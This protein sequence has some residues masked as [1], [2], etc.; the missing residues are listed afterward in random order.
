MMHFATKHLSLPTQPAAAVG[1][2]RAVGELYCHPTATASASATASARHG[3]G[4]AYA[5]APPS[6]FQA[7]DDGAGHVQRARELSE[8]EVSR[9]MEN[10]F[11]TSGMDLQ[12]P[13]E[14]PENGRGEDSLSLSALSGGCSSPESVG[15]FSGPPSPSPSSASLSGVRGL[16]V[17]PAEARGHLSAH[18]LKQLQLA[19]AQAEEERVEREMAEERADE[20]ARSEAQAAAQAELNAHL[21]KAARAGRL[22]RVTACIERGADVNYEAQSCSVLHYAAFY[23]HKHIVRLLVERGADVNKRNLSGVTPL[24]WALEKGELELMQMLVERGADVNV[25]DCDELTPLHKAVSTKQHA[26][27]E[28]LLR[29]CTATID[30]DAAAS[31]ANQRLTA[32]HMAATVG[33][34]TA[35]RLLLSA[36]ASAATATTRGATPL[37]KAAVRGHSEAV[38]VLVLEGGAAVDA[39]DELG[40]TP[41]HSAAFYHR[42]GA[43]RALRALGA[44]PH[45]EDR[46]GSS[47]LA[48]AARKNFAD[49]TAALSEP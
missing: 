17:P 18:D 25:G 12:L 40:R 24:H 47:A 21:L 41:L 42:V 37:H 7:V 10:F 30:V 27:L 11:A 35:V 3:D 32:L 34:V 46:F 5:H 19:R 9:C 43:V 28:Y 8:S 4:E 13:E 15:S 22:K 20:K 6:K 1:S 23:N 26:A 45:L 2:K 31:E 14:A 39:P 16:R 49:V 33:D 48:L 44:D 29:R 36:G 38:R